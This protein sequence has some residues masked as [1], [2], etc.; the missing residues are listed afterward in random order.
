MREQEVYARLARVYDPELDQPLTELGFIGGVTVKGSQVHV[1]FRLPTYWCAAN[2][3]FLMAADIRDRVSELPWVKQVV[4][5]LIDHFAAREINQGVSGHKSFC[6][7]FPD[8]AAGEL[9]ELRSLFRW[10]SF[11]ARQERVL[12]LLLHRGWEDEQI[13]AMR[14]QELVHCP[15]LDQDGRRLVERYLAVRQEWGLSDDPAAPAFS[16]PNGTPLEPDRFR[17][18]L[19]EARR[20]RLSMEFNSAF[21]RGLLQTRY[22]AAD[23]AEAS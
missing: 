17:E 21:C 1:Q 22:A 9:E 6:D 12:R 13:M 3:A 19:Q 4:V 14:L 5:E 8:L 18:H 15:G 20:T 11:L 23:E 2:F 16:H 7:S 10:K